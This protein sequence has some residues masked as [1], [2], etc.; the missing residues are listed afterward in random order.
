MLRNRP[1]ECCQWQSMAGSTIA[2]T[3]NVDM[4]VGILCLR[5]VDDKLTIVTQNNFHE[6]LS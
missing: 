2:R 5:F 6:T 1:I 4:N 3:C